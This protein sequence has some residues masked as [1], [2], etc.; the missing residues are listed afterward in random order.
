MY[1][2]YR[3]IIYRPIT[4]TYFLALF[5]TTLMILSL[6]IYTIPVLVKGLKIPI[7]IAFLIFYSALIGSYINIPIRSYETYEPAI[8]L[9][10]IRIFGIKWILPGID[11]AVKRTIVAI[12]VGGALIPVLT[13]IFLLVYVIPVY[14]LNPFSTYIKTLIALIAVTYLINRIAKIIPGLGIAVPGAIPPIITALISI[15]LYQLP[16]E[17]NPAIIAYISG[18]LGT[19]IGADLL[20]LNKVTKIRARMVS[21]GG[22][23]TFDGI[24][25][26][27]LIAAALTLLAV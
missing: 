11:W 12:N 10:E 23:G 13:S 14:E 7:P 2:S 19:L 9:R 4:V 5:I 17:S 18:T 26:T 8:V 27:G 21:I 22:A 16:P 6:L 20:N 3:S 25:L 24:Y 15:L 1:R